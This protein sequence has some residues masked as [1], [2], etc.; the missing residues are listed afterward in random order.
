M[1]WPNRNSGLPGCRA[2]TRS[3]STSTSSRY[4]SNERT[5]T[6]SP[7]RTA[8]AAEVHRIDC[9]AVAIQIV[10][11]PGVAAAMFVDAVDDD[12]RGRR[13]PLGQPPLLEKAE[14]IAGIEAVFVVRHRKLPDSV[15]LRLRQKRL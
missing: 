8:V 13:L 14:S 4:S 1:L 9:I 6:R 12:H 15:P 2:A 10:G 7:V 3:N 11:Q 5:R